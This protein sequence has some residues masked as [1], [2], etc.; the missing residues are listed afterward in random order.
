MGTGVG[1]SLLALFLLQDR[2][3]D[4]MS[5]N[6]QSMVQVAVEKTIA[7]SQRIENLENELKDIREKID[8]GFGDMRKNLRV[9]IDRLGDLLRLSTADRFTKSE[10]NRYSEFIDRRLDKIEIEIKELNRQVFKEK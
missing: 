9:E 5:Q 1:G 4:L 10:Q 3:I 6:Q 7:N 8:E 2:G